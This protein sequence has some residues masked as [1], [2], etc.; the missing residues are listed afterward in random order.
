MDQESVKV[1]RHVRSQPAQEREIA[2]VADRSKTQEDA[3]VQP[4]QALD[5]TDDI[6]GIEQDLRR[7]ERNPR[8]SL[9]PDSIRF[10]QAAGNG[11]AAQAEWKAKSFGLL[12]S[13]KHTRSRVFDRARL[14]AHQHRAADSKF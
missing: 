7:K 10:V 14:A 1:L 11:D 13:L 3:R 12:G 9:A 8:C 2:F 5:Q 4:V 6:I